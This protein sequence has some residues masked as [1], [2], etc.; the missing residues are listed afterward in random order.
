MAIGPADYDSA[1]VLGRDIWSVQP[2]AVVVVVAWRG[3]KWCMVDE[4]QAWEYV[5]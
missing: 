1:G 3:I 2:L 4:C 5:Q